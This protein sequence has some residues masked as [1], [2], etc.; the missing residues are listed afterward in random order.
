MSNRAI[1]RWAAALATTF[2]LAGCVKPAEGPCKTDID[3]G[4]DAVCV[5]ATVNGKEKVKRCFSTCTHD[6][7]CLFSGQFSASCRPIVDSASGP[8]A[9]RH[10]QANTDRMTRGAIRVCRFENDGVR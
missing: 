3:C 5:E 8:G 2:A 4:K 9:I 1:P 7:D 10:H 6:R